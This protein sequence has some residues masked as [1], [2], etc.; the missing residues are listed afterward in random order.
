MRRKPDNFVAFV[1]EPCRFDAVPFDKVD[2][3][4]CRG[5]VRLQHE[6]FALRWRAVCCKQD[7]LKECLLFHIF[8]R[9]VLL[10]RASAKVQGVVLAVRDPNSRIRQVAIKSWFSCGGDL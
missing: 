6:R 7:R 4:R 3:C 5:R 1:E 10:S 2:S 8:G 9:D